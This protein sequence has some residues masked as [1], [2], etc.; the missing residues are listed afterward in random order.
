MAGASVD[1]PLTPAGTRSSRPAPSPGCLRSSDVVAPPPD[2]PSASRRQCGI[3]HQSQ[4]ARRP[5]QMCPLPAPRRRGP[6]PLCLRRP[7]SPL[8]IFGL[9][10]PREPAPHPLPLWQ[11]RFWLPRHQARCDLD[12]LERDRRRVETPGGHSSFVEM[13]DGDDVIDSMK[14]S[15]RDRKPARTIRQQ[16]QR[17]GSTGR[18]I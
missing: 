5:A 7:P 11:I 13:V 16:G 3:G 2:P 17:I 15:A 10:R 9:R 8:R 18:G 6:V 4:G 1:P 14:S 12:S